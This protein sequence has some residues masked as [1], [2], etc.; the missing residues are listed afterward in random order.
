MKKKAGKQLPVL[1]LLLF[2]LRLSAQETSAYPVPTGNPMQLFY[3][4]RTPNANT[5]VYELNYKDGLLN[6][7][8]PVHVFWIRYDEQGQSA[9][10]SF[11]QRKF[12]YGITTKKLAQDQYELHFVSYRKLGMQLVKTKKD[13]YQVLVPVNGKQVVLHSIFIH[14]KSGGSF[15]SPNIDYVELN[16]TD[17]LTAE[18]V[19]AKLKI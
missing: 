11:I 17:V 8:S 6:E 5:I 12:A 4:Q 16:G 18:P 13:A 15:W 10:L 1:L 9:E 3:L 7:E 2:A 19:K 14:I